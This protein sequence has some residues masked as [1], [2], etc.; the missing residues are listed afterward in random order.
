MF[1]NLFITESFKRF[2]YKQIL[3]PH[4]RGMTDERHFF[5]GRLGKSMD[6]Q[7]YFFAWS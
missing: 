7:R 2:F 3:T 5:S 4:E 1:L 6:I